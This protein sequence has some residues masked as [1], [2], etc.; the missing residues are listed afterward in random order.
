MKNLASDSPTL[1]GVTRHG[2]STPDRASDRRDRGPTRSTRLDR[3][4]SSRPTTP[5]PTASSPTIVPP[6]AC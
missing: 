1:G 6:M 3:A 4:C 2:G 5:T